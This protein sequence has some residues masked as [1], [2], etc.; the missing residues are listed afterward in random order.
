[1]TEN[2]W[3][4]IIALVVLVVKAAIDWRTADRDR[5]WRLEDQA[6]QDA[7]MKELRRN[8]DITE[9]VIG[10]VMAP[11]DATARERASDK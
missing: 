1:M 11:R 10:A 7:L 9:N 2:V 3:L 4:A 8:S 6:R 5:R